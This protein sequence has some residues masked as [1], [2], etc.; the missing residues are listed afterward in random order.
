[1]AKLAY[2][3]FEHSSGRR[4]LLVGNNVAD[5]MLADFTA[6]TANTGQYHAQDVLG[7]PRPYA[8]PPDLPAE[9]PSDVVIHWGHV[10]ELIVCDNW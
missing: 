9:M 2:I 1:M 6:F 4:T 3:R 7:I 5:Q 8:A 10:C